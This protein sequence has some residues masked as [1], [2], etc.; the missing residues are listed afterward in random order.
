MRSPWGRM[1]AL[2]EDEPVQAGLLNVHPIAWA[3]STLE[4]DARGSDR[5][6]KTILIV[7]FEEGEGDIARWYSTLPILLGDRAG[8]TVSS[9]VVDYR[10]RQAPVQPAALRSLSAPPILVGD[11][12]DIAK[13]LERP[14]VLLLADIDFLGVEEVLDTLCSRCVFAWMEQGTQ[15]LLVGTSEAGL[16]MLASALMQA[17]WIVGPLRNRVSS[18]SAMARFGSTQEQ[19]NKVCL[20]LHRAGDKPPSRSTVTDLVNNY[21]VIVQSWET[22]ESI[23]GLFNV[24]EIGAVRCSPPGQRT[25][26]TLA[27]PGGC[28]YMQS[29]WHVDGDAESGREGLILCPQ[30]LP[31]IVTPTPIELRLREGHLNESGI[32]IVIERYVLSLKLYARFIEPKIETDYVLYEIREG[33]LVITDSEEVEEDA[34]ETERDASWEEPGVLPSAACAHESSATDEPPIV[35]G[36]GI[37]SDA[38]VLVEPQID[39]AELVPGSSAGQT[40]REL[41]RSI[42][43]V[44]E[45]SI[46][47]Q[48][49]AMRET[50]RALRR[51][52][53]SAVEQRDQARRELERLR[54]PEMLKEAA[55][56]PAEN[57]REIDDD[58]GLPQDWESLFSWAHQNF[59]GKIAFTSR[60]RRVARK[61]P[62]RDIGQ[63]A[64]AIRLLAC[65]Y[66][67]LVMIGGDDCRD[68]F[69]AQCI[70][71]GF[72]VSLTG[73]AA[74]DHR[75]ANTYEAAWEGRSY[76]MDRHLQGSSSRDVTRGLR[77]YFAMVGSVL[78]IGHLPNHLRNT[79]T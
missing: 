18:S 57:D 27:L 20:H 77:I 31:V 79:L 28:L 46:D 13:D 66:H 14:D 50:I 70:K 60:A 54:T 12:T 7:R 64:R 78:V 41:D 71:Q 37:G 74:N 75:T 34:N 59:Q 39:R 53:A 48:M 42:G 68:A 23:I 51:K 8:W 29:G 61:S 47:V 17:G 76:A 21:D 22:A 65:E 33:C 9:V 32:T 38:E 4:V 72:S 44:V 30:R 55:V 10:Y 62:F 24:A 43:E 56:L 1:L 5:R 63:V 52:L 16:A 49:E 25:G 35:E 67:D 73:A 40:S 15:V 36:A 69:D 6:Q 26:V 45:P 2:R 19:E 58:D 11:L 3:V